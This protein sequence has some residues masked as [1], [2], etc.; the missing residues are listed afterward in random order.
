MARVC[1][2]KYDML[3][4]ILH[5][6][7][8]SKWLRPFWLKP[9]APSPASPSSRLEPDGRRSCSLARRGPG[10]RGWSRSLP[11]SYRCALFPRHLL[12]GL[13]LR[14]LV[15]S[16]APEERA[17]SGGALAAE[18]GEVTAPGQR[19]VRAHTASGQRMATLP[20]G[21]AGTGVPGVDPTSEELAVIGDLAAATAWTGL[22]DPAWQAFST[23]L[24]GPTLLRQVT[25]TARIDWDIAVDATRLPGEDADTF[26]PLSAV[27]KGQLEGLRRV[28]RIRCGLAPGDHPDA[29]AAAA[30]AAAAAAYA[31]GAGSG[32]GTGGGFCSPPAPAPPASARRIN[33]SNLV[34][35]SLDAPVEPLSQAR[36]RQLFA[37]YETK[38]GGAP[39]EDVEPTEDQLAAVWQLYKSDR[40]PYTDFA[41]FGPHAR[42]LL[43]KLVYCAYQQ[44]PDG[45]FKKV[46]LPGPPD[47][48]HWW[49]C[50]RVFRTTM[51]L[52]ELA[53][54]EHL[55]V[56]AESIRQLALRYTQA[57]WFIVYTGDVR[58][59]SEHL[60]RIRRTA[61]TEA[62]TAGTSLA[63]PWTECFRRAVRDKAWWDAEV[64]DPA[65]LYLTRIT[66]ARDAVDSGTAQPSLESAEGAP[67][68]QQGN[69]GG[70]AKRTA[71]WQDAGPP[72]KKTRQER[73]RPYR[74][75]AA[76]DFSEKQDGV[77]VKN[78]RGVEICRKFQS[79]TCSGVGK[80][81]EAGNFVHQCN[82]CLQSHAASDH[83][84]SG[85]GG[86][87][88]GGKGGKRGGGKGG[89]R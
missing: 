27:A 51:L 74:A 79:G 40:V 66:S 28:C 5:N 13:Q 67:A 12:R 49:R 23:A 56:Y 6:T 85:R 25:A 31:T 41:V 61:E 87:K 50:W 18:E 55:D 82:L 3:Y 88:G 48:E 45:S 14:Y 68:S 75:D 22:P 52:L 8:I 83:A 29:L 64:R 76:Q 19:G 53:E 34:D 24:G 33:L 58:L 72:K 9:G 70:S 89:K 42:R 37:D 4:N 16:E 15:R 73:D 1:A 38:H 7:N 36:I 43:Q 32:G 21:D 81:C 77:F 62:A 54:P 78:R 57:C 30:A 80:H 65:L 59:R 35:Q 10:D 84:Q 26:V 2:Y 20:V 69:L 71:T 63:K 39:H 47:F 60:E 46:E 11:A 86:G 17:G 44:R